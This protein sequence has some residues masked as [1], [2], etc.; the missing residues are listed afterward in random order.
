MTDTAVTAQ[1]AGQLEALATH[2]SSRGFTATI[3]TG[4][5][6]PCVK[7]VSKATSQLHEDV[8]AAPAGDESWWF[9]WSWADRIAPIGD[10]AAAA[11]AIAYVLTP[12]VR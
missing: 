3:V 8:Y 6:H 9:W 7:V 10:V 1:V 5:Q 11:S 2:L 4:R 12:D